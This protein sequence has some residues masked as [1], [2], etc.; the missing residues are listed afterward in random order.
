VGHRFID[1]EIYDTTIIHVQPE[2]L[3]SSAYERAGL[4]PRPE[5]TY[6]IGY[7]YWEL[8]SIPS[9]WNSAAFDCDEL[10]T[11]TEFVAEG[12]RQHY[13]QPIKVL[14]PGLEIAPFQLLPKSYFDL[15]G[16]KFTFLFAFH[17]TSVMERKNP[18]ALI[19]AFKAAF[20][21]DDSAELVIKTSFGSRHPEQF[22]QLKEAAADANVRLIDESFSRGETLSLIANCDAYVSLHRSEGLG[23]T[24][25]EAMLLGRPVIA[26]GYSGNLSFM[27]EA[28]SL[29]VDYKLV[30]L[31]SVA[32]PYEIGQQWAQPSIEHAAAHM[33]RLYDDRTFAADLGARAKEDLQKRLN[34]RV[35]GSAMAKRLD[36]INALQR[37]NLR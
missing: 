21:P 34:F 26:T 19:K 1:C 28:N 20:R 37:S 10:W 11:A 32:P 30:T 25:A 2:P 27:D 18:F 9:S 29:L 24:M 31:N 33:R 3:F 12:L 17:M 13:K 8:G 4:R 15:D 22:A 5:R 14:F 36:E 16:S 6:R 35:S 7:W 23:L